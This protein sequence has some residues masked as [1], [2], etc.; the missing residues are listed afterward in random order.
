MAVFVAFLLF[1][2]YGFDRFYIGEGEFVFPFG[3]LTALGV[4]SVSTL[5]SYYSGDRAVLL[6]TG[7]QPIDRV[8]STAATEEDTLKLRQLDNVVEEMSIAAGLP[9][10]KVYVV[11][12]PD[13]NAFATGRDPEHASIAVT[14]GLLDAVS[15]DEL[16]GVV[17]HELSHVRNLDIRLMTVIAAMVGAIALLSDWTSRGLRHSSSGGGSRR[18]RGKDKG[19]GAIILLVIWI[20]AILLAPII[21]Q[22]LAMMVSRGR[23]YLAD[24]SG[25]ELTRNPLA[26]AR[27][28][29]KIEHAHAPTTSVKRGTAHLCIA[30]PLGRSVGLRQGWVPDLLASHPPMANRITAL[31]QMGFQA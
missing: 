16:Q 22:M 5:A 8:L 25:A 29:E 6:S 2:G 26:L 20:V 3:T 28:L 17:A 30:D 12:D 11:P 19:G 13:P 10:P 27:A 18:R 31:R 23:E 21:G 4:G 9:K 1:L 15:R 7:A 24:A 14:R